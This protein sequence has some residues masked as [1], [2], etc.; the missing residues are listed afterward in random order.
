MELCDWC[1]GEYDIDGW[2]DDGEPA[3]DEH[4]K[5]FCSD[6]CLNEHILAE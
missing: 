6:D 2:L 1:D 3:C 5:Q 4:H